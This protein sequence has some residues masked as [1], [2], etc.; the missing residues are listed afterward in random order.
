MVD[1]PEA[2]KAPKAARAIAAAVIVLV[3]CL[4]GLFILWRRH[5]ASAH[6]DGRLTLQLA[7]SSFAD[8]DDLPQRMTCDG[9][10]DSPEMHWGAPPAAARSFAL[11]MNDPDAPI[12]FTHWLVYNIPANAR[13]LPEGASNRRALPQGAE[14]GTN[15]FGR[16]GYG[17]PCPPEGKM[18]HYVF[19][20][21][22]LD[23]KLDLPLAASKNEMESAI[24]GHI[25]AEGRIVGTYQH[26]GE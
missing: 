26:S 22:A 1:R 23:S 2:S 4:V 13:A 25:L 8:G 17:G 16:T 12:D 5:A 19:R 10:G 20:L 7:S 3:I 18:H 9:A 15:S 14:E 6:V 24:A 11:V 21:Y